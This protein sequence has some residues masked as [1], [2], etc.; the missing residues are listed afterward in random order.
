MRALW[1]VVLATALSLQEVFAKKCGDDSLLDSKCAELFPTCPDKHSAAIFNGCYHC[2]HDETCKVKSF[3]VVDVKKM[4]AIGE[5]H[6]GNGS[7]KGSSFVVAAVFGLVAIGTV[8]GAAYH[9]RRTRTSYHSILSKH[10]PDQY[11]GD[12]MDDINPFCRNVPE[13]TASLFKQQTRVVT[14]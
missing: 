6:S 14:V 10:Q 7:E 13:E 1:I 3:A 12:E 11:D 5:T 4:A 8:A 2:A 9:Y